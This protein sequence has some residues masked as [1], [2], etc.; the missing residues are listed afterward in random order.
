M[1]ETNVRIEC[2]TQFYT[3]R[4]TQKKNKK[5]TMVLGTWPGF[6]LQALYV[7]HI[8]SLAF[9]V[10]MPFDEGIIGGWISVLMIY[11]APWISDV[12]DKGFSYDEDWRGHLFYWFALCYTVLAL[13]RVVSWIFWPCCGVRPDDAHTP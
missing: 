7:T 10:T 5:K 6:W 1:S 4:Q 2:T 3:Q 8:F 12:H 13:M 9:D 11:M